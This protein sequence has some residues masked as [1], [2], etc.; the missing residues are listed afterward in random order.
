MISQEEQKYVRE[1]N[2]LLVEAIQEEVLQKI[3]ELSLVKAGYRELVA[4]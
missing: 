2:R 3:I 4:G 1:Q